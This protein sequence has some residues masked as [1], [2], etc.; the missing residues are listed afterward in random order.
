MARKNRDVRRYE[1]SGDVFRAEPEAVA[2]PPVVKPPKPPKPAAPARDVSSLGLYL[3]AHEAVKAWQPRG[4][5]AQLLAHLGKHKGAM[6]HAETTGLSKFLEGKPSVT[7]EEVLG[8]LGEGGHLGETIQVPSE[9]YDAVDPNLVDWERPTPH[10][11]DL[12][13][14]GPKENYRELHVTAPG[15]FGSWQDGHPEYAHVKNPV[16]RVR[17]SDR[18]DADGDRVLMMDEL[19]GPK[20]KHQRDM[21]EHLRDRIFEIGIKRML[22]KAVEGGYDKMA[23]TTGEQQRKRYN[24]ANHVDS[25]KISP[26]TSGVPGQEGKIWLTG[27]KVGH[28]VVREI[29]PKEELANYVGA[30]VAKRLEESGEVSGSGLDVGGHGLASV[31]DRTIPSIVGKLL[32][33]AGGRVESTQIGSVEAHE[34]NGRWQLWQDAEDGQQHLVAGA[35]SFGSEEQARRWA[36]NRNTVHSL[37][38]TPEIAALVKQGFSQYERDGE[39]S[40]YDRSTDIMQIVRRLPQADAAAYA[41]G[42]LHLLKMRPDLR[43]KYDVNDLAY[44]ESVARSVGRMDFARAENDAFSA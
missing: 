15:S 28:E 5:P 34:H 37:R 19:Q 42:L 44:L 10:F 31:Y 35:P 18:V 26:T 17:H 3:P 24:L 27:T 32:K 41:I 14:P 40:K 33:K 13:L 6:A 7:R 12:Q 22:K 21:P 8:H 9:D 16:V 11:R 23:W 36:A 1:E 29:I 30:N 2:A 20:E 38:I 39:P 43:W 25:L 4:T